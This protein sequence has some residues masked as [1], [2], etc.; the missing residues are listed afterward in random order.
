MAATAHP[1][2]GASSP[3]SLDAGRLLAGIGA[4]ALLISLFLDWYGQSQ[5][6][7]VGE[8]NA[9]DA[10]ISAWTSFE[11]VD[12]LLAA[13]ALATIAWVIEGVVSRTG[14]P[15]LPARFASLAGPVAFA[16]VL[17]SIVNEPPQL[18]FLD[19]DRE[20]GVWVALVGAALITI[21]ALLR[22]ARISLVVAA[23]DRGSEDRGFAAGPPASDSY[24]ETE[25]RPLTE[26]PTRRPPAR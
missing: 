3:R 1:A 11:L 26:D 23:R 4:L 18:S 16:L 20:A 25:T 9:R 2:A 19:P 21:G 15:L 13:L 12:I 22:V 5:A 6:F 8:E 17:V 7:V 24:P 10:G 14:G